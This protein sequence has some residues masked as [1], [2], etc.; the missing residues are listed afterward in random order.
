MN[1]KDVESVWRVLRTVGTM[2]SAYVDTYV[3]LCRHILETV[4]LCPMWK[5][6]LAAIVS[7]DGLEQWGEAW[8]CFYRLRGTYAWMW[9]IR[10]MSNETLDTYTK[11]FAD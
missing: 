7:G 9:A 5:E 6:G 8:G 4:S 11:E 3:D 10:F 2:P 1:P